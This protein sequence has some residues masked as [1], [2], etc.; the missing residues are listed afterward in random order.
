MSIDSPVDARVGPS[1]PSNPFVSVMLMASRH[2]E[3]VYEA[4]ESVHRQTL[5]PA[6]YELVVV[7]DYDDADLERKIAAIGGRSVRVEPGDI[8]AAIR[9]GIDTS[10]GKVVAFLDDDDRYLPGRL[11]FVRE[12]FQNDRELGFVKNN[13]V[14]IDRL[15]RQRPLHPFRSDQ[16]RNAQA[17]GRITLRGPDRVEQLR[18]LPALGVDFNS[19]SM[20]IRRELIVDF[21]KNLD[22]AD[23]RLLD[24]LAFFSALS[25]SSAI[26]IDPTV[27]TEY[28]IHSRNISLEPQP[29]SDPV[30]RRATFSRLFLPSFE[31]LAVAV[32]RTGDNGSIEEAE[33]LLEVQRAFAALRDPGAPRSEFVRFRRA[34]TGTRPEYLV[35][36]EVQL[37]RALWLFS[38]SPRFGRWM[39][40]RRIRALE[41]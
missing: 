15:G 20:A 26:C 32:R 13:Y 39:Y 29:G 28:R 40:S 17:L 36:T 37:R 24:E 23:F 34:I 7:R 38:I 31:R 10:R 8:G 35:R 3:F 33:G 25:S 2:R 11:A 27:L 9:A 41:T 16:R 6:Q 1:G 18:G 30:S 21:A 5:D 4:I 19:S 12:M 22:L 14:V